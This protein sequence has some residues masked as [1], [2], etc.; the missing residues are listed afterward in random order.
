MKDN[1]RKRLIEI[2]VRIEDLNQI[3]RM[4]S[5][6]HAKLIASGGEWGER[7]SSDGAYRVR[8]RAYSNPTAGRIPRNLLRLSSTC[9]NQRA[10]KAAARALRLQ[11]HGAPMSLALARKLSSKCAC[12]RSEPIGGA[13]ALGGRYKARF[14]IALL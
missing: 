8:H 11:A 6:Q 5:T 1:R 12:S 3:A 7:V 10:Y 4:F 9:A 2:W 13:D 14:A